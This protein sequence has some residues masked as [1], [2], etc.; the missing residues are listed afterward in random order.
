LTLVGERFEP[1]QLNG[2]LV[3]SIGLHEM[4]RFINADRFHLEEVES[5][6]DRITHFEP[7]RRVGALFCSNARQRQIQDAIPYRNMPSES[8]Q[9]LAVKIQTG[10]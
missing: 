8:L 3:R 9:H 2:R 6:Q 5:V 1:V 7:F 4:L 10:C